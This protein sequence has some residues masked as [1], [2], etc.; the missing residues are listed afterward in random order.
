MLTFGVLSKKKILKLFS[1]NF[2]NLFF[3]YPMYASL[4]A[5]TIPNAT[6][7]SSVS[8][9]IS[10]TLIKSLRLY[11]L[12]VYLAAITCKI[13][14]STCNTHIKHILQYSFLIFFLKLRYINF[15]ESTH[16]AGREAFPSTTCT[17]RILSDK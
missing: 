13:N 1:N 8:L 10:H 9:K 2:I 15:R 12:H 11:Y 6:S 16:K 5:K 3:I 7:K 17:Y 14:N 4:I